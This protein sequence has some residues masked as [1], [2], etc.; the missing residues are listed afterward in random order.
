MRIKK[1]DLTTKNILD[2]IKTYFFICFGLAVFAFGWMA[3]LIPCKL[4]G[5]GIGG[6]ATL[7][8]FAVGFPIGIT[9]LILNLILIAIAVKI[10]GPRFG[11]NTIICTVLL[12]LFYTILQP[13]FKQPLVDDTFLCALIGAMLSGAGVG[14]ALNYGGN[15]GGTD[16]IIVIITKFR[17]ISYGKLSLFMNVLIIASSYLIVK[18]IESL[19]YSYVAMIAYTFSSDMVIDGYK[20]TFQFMVFSSKNV[21]IADRIN[22]ELHRGATLLKG[23][24]S[25][26]KEDTEILLVLAHRSDKANITRIIKEIDNTAFISIVKTS[27]VFGKNFDTLRL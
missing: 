1:P 2:Y 7:I 25:Y 10:L 19:V 6:I 3:F 12:S 9:T 11:T 22:N 24:G 17:N 4:M 8:Y 13:V 27:S 5:G 18:S 20:Q 16:I 21:E 23:Y 26:S 14:I 15:T